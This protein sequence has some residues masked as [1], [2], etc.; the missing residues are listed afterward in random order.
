MSISP[1]PV[2][3]KA[4]PETWTS[5]VLAMPSPITKEACAVSND[6]RFSGPSPQPSLSARLTVENMSTMLRPVISPSETSM[7]N[8]PAKVDIISRWLCPEAVKRRLQ[9]GVPGQPIHA[10]KFAEKGF[11]LDSLR[12]DIQLQNRQSCV[13]SSVILAVALPP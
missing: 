1:P 11:S 7:L 10:R 6:V 13:P 12:I 9:S 2:T 3:A 5:V 8:L 4:G